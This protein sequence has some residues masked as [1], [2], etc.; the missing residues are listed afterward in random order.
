MDRRQHR[1]H[2]VWK[3]SGWDP[4]YVGLAFR[5]AKRANGLQRGI[6]QRDRVFVGDEF[7]PLHR[8]ARVPR[9]LTTQ[10][11]VIE[12]LVP[13]QRCNSWRTVARRSMF[14]EAVCPDVTTQKKD[15]MFCELARVLGLVDANPWPRSFGPTNANPCSLSGSDGF[16]VLF[17]ASGSQVGSGFR[18]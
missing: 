4:K 14:C 7:V 8:P 13:S 6:Q 10:V 15:T 17:C 9:Q 18:D 5:I 12:G 2:Q 1:R 3:Q 11:A 16:G